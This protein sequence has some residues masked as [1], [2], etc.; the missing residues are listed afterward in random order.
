MSLEDNFNP[1]IWSA[2]AEPANAPDTESQA[3]AEVKPV[4]EANQPTD[5]PA[6]AI[7]L[8]GL[9]GPDAHGNAEPSSL[10]ELRRLLCE[11]FDDTYTWTGPDA[12]AGQNGL[13]W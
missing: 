11:G 13:P 4:L 12:A 8:S 3:E 2:S 1:E 6:S 5:N 10:S 9:D 7:A